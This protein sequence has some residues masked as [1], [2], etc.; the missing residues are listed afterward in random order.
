MTS[1]H[2]TSIQRILTQRLYCPFP[3]AINPHR[4]VVTRHIV[5]WGQRFGLLTP[6]AAQQLLAARLDEFVARN[7][8][9]AARDVLQLA[10][11]WF[12][13]LFVRDDQADEASYGEEQGHVAA[14]H[15]RC[16]ALL[17]GEQPTS[18]DVPL[19]AALADLIRQWRQRATPQQVHAFTEAIKDYFAAVEQEAVQRAIGSTLDVATYLHVRRCS[20]GVYPSVPLT[21]LSQ[22]STLPSGVRQH[23]ALHR[24]HAIVNN[25]IAWCNDL[26]SLQKELHHAPPYNLVLIIRAEQGL[27]LPAAIDRVVAMHNTEVHTLLAWEAHLQALELVDE[28]LLTRYF[29]G[30]HHCIRGNLDWSCTTSRY[31]AAE[32]V[33]AA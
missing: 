2:V 13:W 32:L 8:P 6:A 17:A 26:Y 18:A 7:Y 3:A 29:T 24:L 9:H 21:E 25:I 10:A 23:P 27:S 30:L 28:A 12:T 14:L 22:Q 11:C 33:H 1:E 19:T 31:Q 20:S 16:R 5:E 15:V 4:E